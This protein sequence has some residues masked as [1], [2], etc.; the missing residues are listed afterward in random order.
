MRKKGKQP[1]VTSPVLSELFGEELQF[2]SLL[3]QANSH[4]KEHHEASNNT[5]GPCAL[6]SLKLLVEDAEKDFVSVL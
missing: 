2:H 4:N 3:R 5:A 6:D 1:L